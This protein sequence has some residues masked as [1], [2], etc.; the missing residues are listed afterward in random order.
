M[1]QLLAALTLFLGFTTAF[2]QD[3]GRALVAPSTTLEDNDCVFKNKGIPALMDYGLI[4]DKCD[5]RYSP[6]MV[7]LSDHLPEG[8]C[9]FKV[10]Q[11][12]TGLTIARIVEK[13][14]A[15]E[16]QEIVGIIPDAPIE[17]ALP[18]KEIAAEPEVH[19]PIKKQKAF[20]KEKSGFTPKTN[21]EVE[22]G[23]EGYY[24]DPNKIEF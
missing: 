2:A 3:S 18:E 6:R 13:C 14:P 8:A 19:Q 22:K 20:S 16:R 24:I 21:A 11:K 12:M 5:R 23:N 15:L 10:V 9:A 17:E 1:K 4:V 7:L